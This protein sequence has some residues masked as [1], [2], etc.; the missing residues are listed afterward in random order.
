M[1][2]RLGL[3]GVEQLEGRSRRVV[4]WN[5]LL[6]GTLFG[7]VDWKHL[8]SSL[9]AAQTTVIPRC[10]LFE[11]SGQLISASL[12]GFCDVSTNAYVGVVYLLFE[13]VVGLSVKF[14]TSKTRVTPLVV[15]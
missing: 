12:H 8:A 6:S 4:G 10:Y 14:V 11:L 15:H 9:K 5:H 7:R 2:T 1:L 13:T 3:I